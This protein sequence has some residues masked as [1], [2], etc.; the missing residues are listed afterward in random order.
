MVGK[1]I[2]PDA[3]IISDAGGH[4]QAT[5]QPFPHMTDQECVNLNRVLFAAICV[6]SMSAGTS[7]CA[8]LYDGGEPH[9]LGVMIREGSSVEWVAQPFSVDAPSYTTGFGVAVA[10]A[11]GPAGSGFR[12]HITPSL[13]NPVSSAYASGLLI[14]KTTDAEYE[15]VQL[16]APIYLNANQYYF[17]VLIPEPG[18]VGMASHCLSGYIGLTTPNGGA[19]WYYAAYPICA[20][21][22]GYAV[23]EPASLTA[24]AVGT[25]LALR[26][27]RTALAVV[28]RVKEFTVE[29][30]FK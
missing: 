17:L 9:R 12:A 14:P 10:R 7:C 11:A 16:D 18:F 30:C 27:R 6:I 13:Q 24:L 25:L 26:R 28:R 8:W 23:P 19:N 2:L 1:A 5:P 4:F 21:V 20:R 22:D 15:Y 3:G 29:C